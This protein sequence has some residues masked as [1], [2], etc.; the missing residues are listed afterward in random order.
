MIK[1]TRHTGLVVRNLSHS[2]LFYETLGFK[3]WK[4]EVEEGNFIDTV[5][6]IQSVCVETAKLHAPDNSMIELLQYISHPL[7][8]EKQNSP[9]NTLGCSHIAFTVDNIDLTC[10]QILELGGNLVN[11]PIISPSGKVKVAYCHDIDG[12]LLEL[13]EEIL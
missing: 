11:K 7:L 9:S 2:L 12:I 1:K 5:V 6:G 4:R 10:K 8:K 13:V 3:L